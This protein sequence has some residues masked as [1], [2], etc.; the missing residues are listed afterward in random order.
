MGSS[1]EQKLAALLAA[2]RD[3]DAAS[4]TSIWRDMT[5]AEQEG[6]IVT[7]L[8][9]QTRAHSEV[10]PAEPE[11]RSDVLTDA[12]GDTAAMAQVEQT[13]PIPKDVG[14]LQNLTG[15]ESE[16]EA[17]LAV[18]APGPTEPTEY[19]SRWLRRWKW[20]VLVAAWAVTT[21]LAFTG[22]FS[23]FGPMDWVVAISATAVGGGVLV[24]TLVNFAV[25]AIP[26]RPPGS[27]PGD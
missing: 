24:G 8:A 7:L 2:S 14:D 23:A 15:S 10:I 18:R 9:M 22:D 21:I 3:R 6:V 16:D 5:L 26:T 19:W 13:E 17:A 1:D 4:V 11:Q 25:A 27:T 20:S 12:L